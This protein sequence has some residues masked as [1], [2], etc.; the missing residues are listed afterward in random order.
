LEK[1]KAIADQTKNEQANLS[2]PEVLAR[3]IKELELRNQALNVLIK[4]M[5]DK[6]NT[7]PPQT[8]YPLPPP[9]AVSLPSTTP[10][11]IDSTPVNRNNEPGIY[12]LH[13]PFEGA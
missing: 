3:T 4:K 10:I 6:N 9:S 8:Q 1:G 7:P 11:P 5:N 12:L 13:F 2:S